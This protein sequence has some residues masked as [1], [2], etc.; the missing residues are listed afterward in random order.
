MVRATTNL[1]VAAT[2]ESVSMTWVVAWVLYA[3]L[4]PQ[5]AT[6][7]TRA[8]WIEADHD[9]ELGQRRRL[10]VHHEL[11]K[12]EV[13]PH[14]ADDG[15]V[16]VGRARDVELPLVRAVGFARGDARQEERPPAPPAAHP[17]RAVRVVNRLARRG[18]KVDA[19]AVPQARRGA[20]RGARRFGTA[21]AVCEGEAAREDAAQGTLATRARGALVVDGK[22]ARRA[23]AVEAPARVA[24]GGRVAL[25]PLAQHR[26]G[27]H[28]VDALHP[29]HARRLAP[30]LPELLDDLAALRRLV[31]EERAG[32]VA[33]RADE[34]ALL[35]RRLRRQ[36]AA[37]GRPALVLLGAKVEVRA[38]LVASRQSAPPL[39]LL[40]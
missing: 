2:V 31:R 12:V 30:R 7:Y 39:R 10:I 40:R 4:P 15:V 38:R 9:E 19:A 20:K 26:A 8:S 18:R 35:A 36:Q 1:A 25:V 28:R 13:R 34:D 23:R 33:A 3:V 11:V 27:P 16:A 14:L 17:L 6:T 24:D 29:R 22:V 37:R 21:A 32:V 5:P